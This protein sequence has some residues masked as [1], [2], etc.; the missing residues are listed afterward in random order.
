MSKLKTLKLVEEFHQLFDHPVRTQDNH[1]EETLS[2]KEFRYKFLLEELAEMAEAEHLT[3]YMHIC[4]L[5][6]IV[7]IFDG[8]ERQSDQ[9]HIAKS[10]LE[11]AKGA[12]EVIKKSKFV[13]RPVDRVG[14][15]DALV[16]IEYV[17]MGKV[18][19]TGLADVFS[20]AFDEVHSNNM[21]KTCKN[22]EIGA[23]SI[24]Y[25]AT[26][27]HIPINELKLEEKETKNGTV[28]IVKHKEKVKKPINYK[29]VELSRF[30][31]K[32]DKR[33]K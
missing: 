2:E 17:L 6:I 33:K 25:Y 28:Y 12:Y 32:Q 18:I 19:Q 24:R 22:K 29:P 26:E 5:E 13:D 16:D 21:S 8:K 11:D 7:K 1:K 27:E 3:L 10:L 20:K 31:K 9:Y 4:M 23:E 15:L 30:I 14:V